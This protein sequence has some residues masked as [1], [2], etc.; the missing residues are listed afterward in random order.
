MS[1]GTSAYRMRMLRHVLN[2]DEAAMREIEASLASAIA[3]VDTAKR[4]YEPLILNAEER[5]VF[6]DLFRNWTG[7][8][9]EAQ[10]ANIGENHLAR[11]K[12]G[13][14]RN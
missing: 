7:F 5:A 11:L 8:L 3:E 2:T 1:T 13:R 12:E 9:A 4:A 14:C 6:D 10:I